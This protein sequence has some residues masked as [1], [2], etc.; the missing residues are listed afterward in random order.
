MIRVRAPDAYG[1]ARRVPPSVAIGAMRTRCHSRSSSAPPMHHVSAACHRTSIPTHSRLTVTPHPKP[2]L[3]LPP[4]RQPLRPTSR[5]PHAYLIDHR[6]AS[7]ARVL[8][9]RRGRSLPRHLLLASRGPHCDG[10]EA[11]SRRSSTL[12]TAQAE[13]TSIWLR[14]HGCRPCLDN[15]RGKNASPEEVPVHIV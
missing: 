12:R 14:G 2:A 6:D 5:R 13:E 1:F 11:G 15:V 7:Y 10:R 3:I 8:R 9:T 4:Q